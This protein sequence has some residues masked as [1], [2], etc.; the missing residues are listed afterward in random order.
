[1]F[2]TFNS[3]VPKLEKLVCDAGH[4][5]SLAAVSNVSTPPIAMSALGQKQTLQ[6]V[7]EMSA[8]PPEADM[9][10]AKTDVR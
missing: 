5:R 7:G 2:L 1:L 4:I 6:Q 10:V 9:C 8:L 3:S